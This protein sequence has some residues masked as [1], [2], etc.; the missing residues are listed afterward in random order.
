MLW[1]DGLGVFTVSK[2]IPTAWPGLPVDVFALL[3]EIYGD[4]YVRILRAQ[5][6]TFSRVGSRIPGM[7]FPDSPGWFTTAS[8]S[9]TATNDTTDGANLTSWNGGGRFLRDAETGGVATVFGEIVAFGA[10]I[11]LQLTAT[12]L[13]TKTTATTATAS[14]AS[15]SPDVFRQ[16]FSFSLA[17]SREGG[18]AANPRRQFGYSV[19]ARKQTTLAELAYFFIL[20]EVIVASELP[21]SEP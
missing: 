9:Y 20:E 17:N 13:D 12:Y 7:I 21:L 11:D 3:R 4:D 18:S 6:F 10:D 15:S 2:N 14:R 8:A 19:Q 16:T 1:L 5:N